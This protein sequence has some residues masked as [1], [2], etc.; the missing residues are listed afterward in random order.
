LGV[1]PALEGIPALNTAVSLLSES[2]ILSSILISQYLL[3]FVVLHSPPSIMVLIENF[4]VRGSETPGN[5]IMELIVL[6]QI[7]HF[8]FKVRKGNQLDQVL[9]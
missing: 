8:G 6:S 3:D 4:I 2:V 5:F 7:D 1:I 9:F